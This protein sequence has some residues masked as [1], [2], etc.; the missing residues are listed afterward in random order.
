M[1]RLGQG[2][3]S[4]PEQL[5]VIGSPPDSKLLVIAGPGC[6][7]THTAAQ[8]VVKL[9]GHHETD[10]SEIGEILC[11][12]FTRAAKLAM[13]EQ[14]SKSGVLPSVRITTIDSWVSS[15]LRL[16]GIV[17]ETKNATYEDSILALIKELQLEN[18][19]DQL[20]QNYQ[21]LVVDEAQ[22]IYGPRRDLLV[23]LLSSG[24]FFGATILG[25]PAQGIYD[26][27]K[28]DSSDK[29]YSFLQFVEENFI[30]FIRINLVTDHRSKND[31]I[32]SIRNIGSELRITEPSEGAIENTWTV[33]WRLHSMAQGGLLVAAKA[34][35]EAN[36]ATAILVRDNRR[37]M[38]ISKEIAKS[39]IAHSVR[40]SRDELE[41]PSWLSLFEE[42][43]NEK[44]ALEVKPD[45]LDESQFLFNIRKYMGLGKSSSISTKELARKIGNGDLPEY[46]R[47]TQTSGLLV[48]TVHRSKGLEFSKVLVGL[49][50]SHGLERVEEINEARVLFVAMTRSIDSLLRLDLGTKP[51]ATHAYHGRWVD[52]KFVGKKARVPVG[53]EVKPNDFNFV[54]SC[55]NLLIGSKVKLVQDGFWEGKIARYLLTD[56]FGSVILAKI[57]SGFSECVSIE[58]GDF[59]P[60]E[61]TDLY[62]SGFQTVKTPASNNIQWNGR[63]LIK[64][65]TVRGMAMALKG[66][67][68]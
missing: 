50:R 27:D 22:D 13:E 47:K 55:E 61:F 53:L 12:S 42:C 14:I 9:R 44:E 57:G 10:E 40:A 65:P 26:F 43:R 36:E 18:G 41:I 2:E 34:Y 1:D 31:T 4:D 16:L 46:F 33:F 24:M 54:N 39:G 6:G 59:P 19:L 21:H 25:D 32:R 29:K 35:A 67:H 48:S 49:E 66:D 62:L 51:N 5:R 58:W 8:R 63:N 56:D 3:T 68:E 45:F 30:D 20:S 37:V 11:I 23:L 64:V 15:Q 28:S 60:T 17:V 38:Q 52:K 7:K